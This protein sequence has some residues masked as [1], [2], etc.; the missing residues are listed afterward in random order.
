MTAVRLRPLSLLEQHRGEGAGASACASIEPPNRVT[1]HD[2]KAQVG[3]VFE[4]DFAFDSSDT[5]SPN[6]ADQRAVFDHIGTSL[7]DHACSGFNACLCAYGQTGTGKTHTLLGEWSSASQRGIL[8]RLSEALCQQVDALHARLGADAKVQVSYIEIYNESLRD[9]LAAAAPSGGPNAARPTPRGKSGQLQIHTHPSVGVYVENLSAHTIRSH[10]DVGRLVALG[11]RARSTAATSMNKTSS[12]SHAIFSFRLETRQPA[13]LEVQSCMSLIQVVDL[14]GRESEQ[15]SKTTGERFRELTFINQSLFHLASCVHALSDGSR[16]HIPFRNS[17]LTLLLSESFQRNSRTCL[18]AT[19]TPSPSGF[20][21][22]LLTCRF[23]ESAGRIFT[24]PVVNNMT[25]EDLKGQLQ[26]EIQVIRGELERAGSLT[27]I[28]SDK[29]LRSRE[30]LL[31][32]ILSS[33]WPETLRKPGDK[34]A[35]L[36]VAADVVGDYMSDAEAAMRRLD[37]LNAAIAT[38]ICSAETRLAA[39]ETVVRALGFGPPA[40]APA[41]PNPVPTMPQLAIQEEQEGQETARLPSAVAPKVSSNARKSPKG[42][43]SVTFEVS[44]PPIVMLT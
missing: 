26:Q 29:Q 10:A 36:K 9:L 30:A 23:L 14:A 7:V 31:R 27:N 20:E 33:Q 18:L 1:L 37:E 5:K 4:C 40:A 13:A 44:L 16:D 11:S 28:H 6:Y 41:T 21:E 35:F 32:Q 22:N 39:A 24:Y 15:T 17:K 25:I 38:S 8:P 12:R 3:R 43:V 42:E 19:L 34:A 2:P